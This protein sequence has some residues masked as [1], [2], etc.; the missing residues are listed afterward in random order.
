MMSAG[1]GFLVFIWVMILLGP[2]LR[3]NHMGFPEIV[4]T[5]AAIGTVC[6]IIAYAVL[7]SGSK[8]E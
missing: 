1:I 7:G 5:C 6:G 4:I 8:T 3:G 2:G